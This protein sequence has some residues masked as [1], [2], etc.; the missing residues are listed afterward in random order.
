[1]GPWRGHRRREVDEPPWIDRESAHDFER[2]HRDYGRDG[3]FI[4]P[5]NRVYEA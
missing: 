3:C 5:D 2:R 4:V 1:V